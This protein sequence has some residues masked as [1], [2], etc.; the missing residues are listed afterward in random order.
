[1]E[2]SLLEVDFLQNKVD[3]IQKTIG[4]ESTVLSNSASVNIRDEH[5]KQFIQNMD[6]EKRALFSNV[7]SSF[8]VYIRTIEPSKDVSGSQGIWTNLV[9]IVLFGL[10]E[11][12]MSD[13]QYEDCYTYLKKA[14]Q[15]GR[16]LKDDDILEEWRL[17]YGA[18][19]KV[20]KFFNEFVIEQEQ[21][22]I[23][24][25]IRNDPSW[26][27]IDSIEKFINRVIRYRGEFVHSLSF[28]CISEF[29]AKLVLPL[30]PQS[31][32]Q[33]EISALVSDPVN[34]CPTLSIDRV[35]NFILKGIFRKFDQGKIL[36]LEQKIVAQRLLGY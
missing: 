27:G 12:V 17:K 26:K 32:N 33:E 34:W 8:Y 14:I 2:K 19:E 11:K 4:M 15:N 25:A 22:E 13:Y 24:N 23:L 9:L 29:D 18:N 35:I 31:A 20:R 1:M 36:S 10:I 16:V 5:L 21:N 3:F 6:D 30:I 28:Q 7:I